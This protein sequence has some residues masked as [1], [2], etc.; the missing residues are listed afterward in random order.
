MTPQDKMIQGIVE[1]CRTTLSTSD[2]MMP[3]FFVGNSDKMDIIAA[4][5]GFGSNMEKDIISLFV[6]KHI[7]E[8]NA[9]FVLFIS[10]AWTLSSTDDA[11]LERQVEKYPNLGDHPDSKEVVMFQLESADSKWTGTA[12]I[13][14]GRILGEI[15]WTQPHNGSGRFQGFFN[16]A[17]KH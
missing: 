7:K 8:N 12:D 10:E 1:T 14:P 15:S 2:Q 5:D 16:P 4:A 9:T 11:K 3:V 13:L 6:R 17:T